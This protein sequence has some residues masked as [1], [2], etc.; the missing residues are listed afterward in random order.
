MIE[1]LKKRFGESAVSVFKEIDESL[2]LLLIKINTTSPI[3]V[4][5]T[6]G[7][8]DYKMPVH[9]KYAGREYNELFFCLPSYWDIQEEDNPNRYWPVIWLEK[10]AN[11]VK[12]KN[13]WFGPGHTIQCSKDFAPISE[14][15]K[16]NHF[17]LVDP[18]LL[19][20]EMAPMEVSGKKIHFLAGLPIF[21]DEMDYKQ[22]KGTAKLLSK[23]KNK[24]IDEKLDDWRE[25]ILKSRWKFRR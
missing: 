3:T 12:E 22:G 9:E 7:L 11:H 17:M 25:N 4:L 1:E 5:M 21:G 8:S 23:L 20:K 2:Q 18:I 6:C 14:T 24:K 16:Q 10:L 15:L 19:E 13:G